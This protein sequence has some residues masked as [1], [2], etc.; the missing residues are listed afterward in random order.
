MR[1]L[2]KFLSNAALAGQAAIL[3]AAL[4][5]KKPLV[6]NIT[7]LV[8]MDVSANVLLAIGASPAM[9]HAVEE[10]AEFAAMADALV[11]NTGTLSRPFAD[12]MM[13]AAQAAAALGKPWVLDPVG[14]GASAFRN[15]ILAGLM[16]LHPTIIRGNASEIMVLA[17]IA[18]LSDEAVRPRGIDSQHATAAA[19]ASAVALA[20][21]LAC[22]VAA[23]GQVDFITDGKRQR[24]LGNGDA[25]MTRV[26]A[27]G[28]AL[29]AVCAAFAAV[30]GDAFEAANAALAVY[31]VAGEMAATLSRGPGSFR[32]EFLDVLARIAKP[33]LTAC[34]KVL[35]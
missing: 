2:P 23:T 12:S 22:T 10:V 20:R 11:I 8:A 25:V 32:V 28:C 9:V 35:P 3:L 33:D 26:T 1:D 24:R 18:G 27:L 29:S 19:E 14:A 34:L 30:S 4:R 13:L 15:G 16:R 5:A 17:Q 6:H 31:G 21:H 7:N